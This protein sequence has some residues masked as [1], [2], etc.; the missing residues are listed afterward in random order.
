MLTLIL[1][2]STI[3]LAQETQDKPEA[4]P[5]ETKAAELP[6]IDQILDKYVEALGGKTAI[7]KLTSRESKGKLEVAEMGA[8]GTITLLAKTPDKIL[9]TIDV[10]GFGVIQQACN[11]DVAWA[12]DPMRGLRDVSGAELA[13]QK[14]AALFH[15]ELKMKDQYSKM[16]VK[17]KEK[18]GEKDAYVVEATPTEGAVEKMYFDAQTGLLVRFDG[19]R[20]TPDGGTTHVETSREDYKE[21]DGVKVPFTLKQVMPQMTVVIKFDEVKHNVEIEDTKFAKPAAQ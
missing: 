8:G 7:E 10:E 19:D 17:S 14:R 9:L 5:A 11:G 2:L 4:K 15:R 18:I 3:G 6:T 12:N 1:A 21:M 16:E 13:A 20:E